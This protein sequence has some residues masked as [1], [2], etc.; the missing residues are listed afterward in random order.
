M[1][2]PNYLEVFTRKS[3]VEDIETNMQYP[4]QSNKYLGNVE[5]YDIYLNVI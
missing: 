4:S 3:V 5:T 2:S 1:Q